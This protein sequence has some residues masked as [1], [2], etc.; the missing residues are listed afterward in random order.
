VKKSPSFPLVPLGGTAGLFLPHHKEGNSSVRE[1]ADSGLQTASCSID[2][3]AR[4]TGAGRSCSMWDAVLDAAGMPTDR[5]QETMLD[6]Q[7]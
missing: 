3:A 7:A 1:P 5:A 2:H 6:T 4:Q